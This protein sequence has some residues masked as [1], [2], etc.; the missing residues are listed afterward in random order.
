MYKFP[1][2]LSESHIMR[3]YLCVCIITRTHTKKEVSANEN[4][5]YQNLRAIP[6][7]SL[8]EKA[9]GALVIK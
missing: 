5:I 1:S 8:T 3:T 6:E 7:M 9:F 4:I 2:V